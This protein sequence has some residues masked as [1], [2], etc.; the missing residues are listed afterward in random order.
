M[1]PAERQALITAYTA[2]DTPDPLPMSEP[3]RIHLWRVERLEALGLV[4][5]VAE[6]LAGNGDEPARI[7][8][9]DLARLVRA[10]CPITTALEVLS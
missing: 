7:D 3:E 4:P 1:T 9:H 8:H 10:G 2:G 5:Y 6:Y